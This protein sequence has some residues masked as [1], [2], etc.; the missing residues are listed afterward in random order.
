MGSKWNKRESDTP[1]KDGKQWRHK[2][3]LGVVWPWVTL[4]MSVV[5]CAREQHSPFLF[6]LLPPSPPFFSPSLFATPTRLPLRTVYEDRLR[7]HLETPDESVSLISPCTEVDVALF[8]AQSHFPT[9]GISRRPSSPLQ[10]GISFS[11][12]MIKLH[13]AWVHDKRLYCISC[14]HAAKEKASW[15]PNVCRC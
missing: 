10:L 1:V 8:L 11:F 14:I 2:R 9:S 12:I 4:Q 5:L 15:A 6:L 13:S 3:T 7:S